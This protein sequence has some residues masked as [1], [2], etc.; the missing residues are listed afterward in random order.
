[1]SVFVHPQGIC[2][3]SNVGAGSKIWAFAHVLPGAVIGQKANICD[4]VF[5]EN[6]V[7]IGD[8]VTI[9]CGVQIWDGIQIGDRVFIGP[10]VTFTNDPFPRSKQYP[11]KYSQTI[12]EEG[13]SLGGGSVILPGVRIGQNAMVGAGAVVTHDVPPN[14]VV[15]GNPARIHG[16]VGAGSA[17]GAELK[18]NSEPSSPLQLPGGAQLLDL[19]IARDSRGSLSALE[20]ANNIPFIPQRFFCVYGVPTKDIRGEHAHRKCEQFLIC[21]AGSVRAIVDDGN[22]RSEVV[23]DSP[24]QGLYMPAMVWGTQYDYSPDAVLGVFASL[25]Y[26]KDDYLRSYGEFLAEVNNRE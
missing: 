17:T 19:P 18:T 5:I 20:F 8:Q 14:A 22:D 9:K 7:I 11:S 1:M 24:T 15:Y 10:N 16:Y 6:D 4:H 13:A 25:P 21:L 23:L 3:S 26:D 12:V 2:E